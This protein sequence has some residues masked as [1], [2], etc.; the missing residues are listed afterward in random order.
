M[1]LS[2]SL[3]KAYTSDRLMAGEAQRLAEFIAWGPVI[4]QASRVM[5]KLGVFQA[6][7]DAPEGLTVAEVAERTHITPYA[8]TVLLEASLSAGTVIVDDTV[9]RFSLS[10]A[11]WFLLNDPR[12]RVN[13]DF[14]HDVNYQGMFRLDEAIEQG[15]P[16]GLGHFGAW[17]TLYEGLSQLPEPAR[18]SWLAFDHFY[19]DGAFD[20]ALDVVFSHEVGTLLDVG[21]NT[22][23]WA[24]RCVGRS[25][26][27]EVTV[28]DLPQQIGMMCRATA[29]VPSRDRIHG[30]GIDML[31]TSARFPAGPWDAI[32]MSQF[33]DC[34]SEEQI[35]SVLSR[36]AAVM[37]PSTR[38]YIM[39]TFWDR[40]RYETATLCLTM[41]SLYFTAMANGN[42]RMYHSEV[43]AR[44]VGEAGLVVET[45]HDNLGQGHSIMVCR[46]GNT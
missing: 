24:T 16:A 44:L 35:V 29:D 1:N 8:A 11:G 14:V 13:L 3:H 40:Q 4:F 33:L 34:F 22:G 36:A 2:P 15:R 12:T 17:D 5:L 39:E 26:R 32:W 18:G 31:D 25:D 7:A 28:L 43:M 10:K 38:L 30:H 9:T 37:T 46:L 42:S 6:I 21:G 23:R 19:S 45:I 20:A 27:V 41:T